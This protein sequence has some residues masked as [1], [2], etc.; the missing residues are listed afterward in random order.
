MRSSESPIWT[1]A[2]SLFYKAV[3]ESRFRFL[4]ARKSAVNIDNFISEMI[5][6]NLEEG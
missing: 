1:E 2:Y 6:Y 3:Y 4:T 5:N